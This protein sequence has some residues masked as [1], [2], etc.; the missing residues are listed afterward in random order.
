MWVKEDVFLAAMPKFL[1]VSVTERI[2]KPFPKGLGLGS[3]RIGDA[4]NL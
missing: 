1:D 2:Y 4:R 3:N